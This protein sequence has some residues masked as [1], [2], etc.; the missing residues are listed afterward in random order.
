M[1]EDIQED[2]ND[3]IENIDEVV[4]EDIFEDEE[5]EESIVPK[6]S[7]LE[8]IPNKNRFIILTTVFTILELAGLFIFAYAFMDSFPGQGLFDFGLFIMPPFIGA[9][10]AYFVENKKEAVAVSFINAIISIPIFILVFG[11][12]IHFAHFPFESLILEWYAY[13]IPV[14]M[15]AFQIVIAYLITRFRVLYRRMGDSSRP[16]ESDKAMIEELKKSRRARGLEPEITE[17][18]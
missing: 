17:D 5:I 1:Q 3:N 6:W 13:L 16:L 7:D 4:E 15:A 2:K 8:Y 12:V 11:L 9:S 10:I 18:E 14:L